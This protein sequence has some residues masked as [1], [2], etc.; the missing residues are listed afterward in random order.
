MERAKSN[1]EWQNSDP[2]R[3]E[4]C[5]GKGIAMARQGLTLKTAIAAAKTMGSDGPP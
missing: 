3:L 2:E 5:R 4:N 1:P